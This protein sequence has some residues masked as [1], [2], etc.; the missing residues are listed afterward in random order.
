MKKF[1]YV[2]SIASIA[3]TVLLLAGALFFD[4][5]FAYI[6]FAVLCLIVGLNALSTIIK[7]GGGY[8]L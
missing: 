2:L 6:T 7:G 3:T 5:I 8:C 1:D 4:V